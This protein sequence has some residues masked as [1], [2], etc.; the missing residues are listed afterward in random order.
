MKTIIL[1]ILIVI[2][3]GVCTAVYLASKDSEITEISTLRDVT[4]KFL[5]QPAAN[6]II[7]LYGL[8]NQKWNGAIF[9][10]TNI[11]DV[12]FNRTRE[13]SI[14]T[15]NQWL[16]N[17]YDRAKEVKMFYSSISQIL[18]DTQKD[19]LGRRHSSIYVPVANEL[20]RLSQSSSKRRILLVYSDLME[21]DLNFSIYDQKNVKSDDNKSGYCT[22]HI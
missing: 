1:I 12:S 10:F 7:P 17:E 5:S 13:A 4:D 21:N 6:E 3:G 18:T 15:A 2:I 8:D 20:N 22:K 16:S 19:T 11:S 14:G 9:H